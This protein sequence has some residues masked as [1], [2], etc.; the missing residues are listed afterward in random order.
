VFR[1]SICGSGTPRD[2]RKRSSVPSPKFTQILRGVLG[3]ARLHRLR[4]NSPIRQKTGKFRSTA[5]LSIGFGKGKAS[6]VPPVRW[7]DRSFS[8]RGNA[9]E[10]RRAAGKWSN[11]F[12]LDTL[13]L[14]R[15]RL[16]PCQKQSLNLGALAPEVIVVGSC[17]I[18]KFRLGTLVACSFVPYTAAWEEK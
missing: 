5:H 16:Q 10:T 17:N 8:P 6:A 15:A 4:K 9:S 3:R 13:Q 7:N 14:G 12:C 1:I 2:L 11:L 18:N